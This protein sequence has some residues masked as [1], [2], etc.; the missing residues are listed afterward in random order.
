MGRAAR[1]LVETHL[2]L[3]V[4]LRDEEL[5]GIVEREPEAADDV[6]RAVTAA[7]LLKERR[8][9]ITSLQH[10]GV[11]VVESEYDRVS[12]RLVQTYLELKRRNL[13]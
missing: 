6:T 10:L 5:E 2:L 11:H 12:E 3:I 1:R 4:V 13:L 9:V 7:A 8:V